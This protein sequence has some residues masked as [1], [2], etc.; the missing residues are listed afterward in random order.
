MN[1][2]SFLY[3]IV[4]LGIV[5]IASL[6]GNIFQQ[7]CIQRTRFE[8]DTVRNEL[9]TARNREQLTKEL[10]EN[11]EGSVERT[12]DIL[13]ESKD[14]VAGIRECINKIRKEYE[15]MANALYSYK[16]DCNRN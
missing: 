7:G 9:A 14:T 2:K 11:V 8:L 1:E 15:E 3:I 4:F 16:R 13:S 12:S 10:V 6:C 5:T